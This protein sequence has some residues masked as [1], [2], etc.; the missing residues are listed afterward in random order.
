VEA[1]KGQLDE[2]GEIKRM[3]DEEA[4]RIIQELEREVEEKER[5][6]IGEE[7]GKGKDGDNTNKKL[8]LTSHFASL[9]FASLR[10]ASLRFALLRFASLRFAS[11]RF[12]SKISS[13]PP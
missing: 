8:V 13:S 1:L 12:A 6:L 10:F 7:R 9:C 2:L 4:N 5:E 11:L 3:R